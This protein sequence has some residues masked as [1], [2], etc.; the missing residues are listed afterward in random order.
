M[1][2]S[3][4][5]QRNYKG[6]RIFEYKDILECFLVIS[7]NGPTLIAMASNLVAMATTLVAMASTLQRNY[8]GF[9]MIE[10]KDIQY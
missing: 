2:H 8:K 9:G 1:G 4:R 3:E 7:S 10:Y 6:F 5:N